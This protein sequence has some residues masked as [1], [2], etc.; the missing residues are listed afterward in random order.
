MA[1]PHTPGEAIVQI[2]ADIL[3]NLYYQVGPHPPLRTQGSGL[4][5]AAGVCHRGEGGAT[6]G[7]PDLHL[8]GAHPVL[9]HLQLGGRRCL[10]GPPLLQVALS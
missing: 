4:L 2:R 10:P 8:P 3:T 6:A 1:T 7:V 9:G 5:R